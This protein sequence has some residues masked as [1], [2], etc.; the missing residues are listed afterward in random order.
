MSLEKAY[1]ICLY[2]KN[3]NSYKILLCQSIDNQNKWGFLK[4]TKRGSETPRKA[5][6]RE[7]YEESGIKVDGK[8]LEDFFYQKN[9]NK[10]VG[11]FMVDGATVKNLDSFFD[12]DMLK[13]KYICAENYQVNFFDIEDLPKIKTKQ[14]IL[15]RK[16]VLALRAKSNSR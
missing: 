14:L 8:N 15:V 9:K 13:K 6:V 3:K 7:F 1:G 11:I 16:V 10:D 4:G 12:A 2:V 5:A